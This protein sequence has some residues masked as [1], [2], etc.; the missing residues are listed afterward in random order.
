MSP[1]T[2]E[3]LRAAFRLIDKRPLKVSH[4]AFM[5]QEDRDDIMYWAHCN[6]CGGSYDRRTGGH[7]GPG[8]DLR[9]VEEVMES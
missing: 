7:P 4:V 8:C 5:S 1:I 3:D 2:K 6:E 9:R